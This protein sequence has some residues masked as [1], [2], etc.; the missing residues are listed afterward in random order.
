MLAIQQPDTPIDLHMVEIME[1]R[2]RTELDTKYVCVV[3]L[4]LLEFVG[5]LLPTVPIHIGT[6]I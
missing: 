4:L 3:L 2:H 5:S 1:M 6:L